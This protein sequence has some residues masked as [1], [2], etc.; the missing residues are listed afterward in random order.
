MKEFEH[1]NLIGK[2]PDTTMTIIQDNKMKQI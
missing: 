1:K 2:R